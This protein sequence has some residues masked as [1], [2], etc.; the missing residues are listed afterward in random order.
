MTEPYAWVDIDS[1]LRSKQTSLRDIPLYTKS[2]GD[3]CGET[4]KRANLCYACTVMLDP[5]SYDTKPEWQGLTDDD[6]NEITKDVIAFKSDVVKFI[7][8]A[9][10]KLQEKNGG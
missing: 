5:T 6:V 3:C 8:E 2:P 10:A 7:R 1:Q 4:C 9:E